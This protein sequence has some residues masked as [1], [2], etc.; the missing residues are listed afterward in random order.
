MLM[1]MGAFEV[2]KRQRRLGCLPSK[3][4]LVSVLAN[5][6]CDVCLCLA[7]HHGEVGIYISLARGKLNGR[8]T[9]VCIL[10]KDDLYFLMRAVFF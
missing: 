5:L 9:K 1:P 4:A 3:R 10:I 8:R 6:L 7:V 2:W